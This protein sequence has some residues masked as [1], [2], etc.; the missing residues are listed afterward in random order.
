MGPSLEYL[1]DILDVRVMKFKIYYKSDYK[2]IKD[3]YDRLRVS[4]L[5]AVGHKVDVG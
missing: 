4:S 3:C 1:A 2:A 5:N